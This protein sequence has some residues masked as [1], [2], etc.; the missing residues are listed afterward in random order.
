MQTNF[1]FSISSAKNFAGVAEE[2][3]RGPEK[4]KRAPW[5]SRTTYDQAGGA[6][7]AAFLF[8]WIVA[9]HLANLRPVALVRARTDHDNS[10]DLLLLVSLSLSRKGP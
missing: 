5:E 8:T 4:I 6:S 10:P 1:E 9:E 2:L 7:Q 3:R